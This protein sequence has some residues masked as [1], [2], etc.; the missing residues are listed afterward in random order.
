MSRGELG[1]GRAFQQRTARVWRLKRRNHGFVG[2][3]DDRR[4]Q[5]LDALDEFELDFISNGMLSNVPKM[6]IAVDDYGSVRFRNFCRSPCQCP[7]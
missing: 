4:L 3:R 6:E 5:V 2:E 7:A 1:H